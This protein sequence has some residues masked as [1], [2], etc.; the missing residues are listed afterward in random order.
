MRISVLYF[1]SL[2]EALGV[3]GETVE[4]PATVATTGA[5]RNWLANS[6]GRAALTEAQALRCARNQRMTGFDEPLADG[7][8]I[9]FFPPV[10]GG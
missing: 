1:A 5:L 4:L 8:E 3:G 6:G 10:T 7:D 2:K 9:A